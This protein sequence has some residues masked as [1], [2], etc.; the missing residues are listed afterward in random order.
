MIISELLV[1]FVDSG[2]GQSV[3]FLCLGPICQDEI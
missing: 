1:D 3:D 2:L